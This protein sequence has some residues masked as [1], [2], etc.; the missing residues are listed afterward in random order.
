MFSDE[1]KH[2]FIVCPFIMHLFKQSVTLYL[3]HIPTNQTE[4]SAVLMCVVYI[5]VVM[6]LAGEFN[7]TLF[8]GPLSH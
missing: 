7:W 2:G 8:A 3:P 5:Q 4:L 6:F 1:H